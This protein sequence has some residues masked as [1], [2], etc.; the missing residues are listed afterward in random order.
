MN[1]HSRRF[2]FIFTS[3]AFAVVVGFSPAGTPSQARAEDQAQSQTQSGADKVSVTLS[4]PTRPAF[5]KAGL[6]NGGI[7]VKAYD[8]KEVVVEARV[9]NGENGRS[10]SGPKR[11]TISTTGFQMSRNG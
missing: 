11:L 1:N 4:D 8:G 6:I 10:E 9:R 2:R 3:A 7:T 5:V